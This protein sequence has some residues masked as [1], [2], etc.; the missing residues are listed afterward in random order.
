MSERYSQK[1]FLLYRLLGIIV[2]REFR[3]APTYQERL[4]A[5]LCLQ[6]E[7]LRYSN[8]VLLIT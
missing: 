3:L 2:L 8:R 7:L 4:L 5:K 6:L 1:V